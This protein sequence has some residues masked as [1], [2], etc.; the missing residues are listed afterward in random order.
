[1]VAAPV[2]NKQVENT[3][4]QVRLLDGASIQS[5]H[6]CDLVLHQIP[7]TE[8]K[9]HVIPGLSTRSLLSVGQLVDSNCSVIFDKSKVQVLHKN[10]K[11]LEGRQ[12]LKNGLWTVD[13]QSDLTAPQSDHTYSKLGLSNSIF[14]N[15]DTAKPN[16]QWS[17]VG[18]S[19]KDTT[20]PHGKFC[21]ANSVCECSNKK[22][23]V[24]FFHAAAFSP[25]SDTWIK[26][27]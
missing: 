12:N 16:H 6:T 18:K 7:D 15:P 14:K 27:V 23:L 22:D 11:I 24:R 1:M 3:P 10:A 17:A 5:S 4:I 19:N 20:Y 2:A 26:V 25:L 21:Q 13:L 9:A 8:K